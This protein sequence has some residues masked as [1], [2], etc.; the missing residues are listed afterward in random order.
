MINNLPSNVTPI[1]YNDLNVFS[2]VCKISDIVIFL[3]DYG[4]NIDY[5]YITLLF[6]KQLV[7]KENKLFEDLF[8]N[9]KNAYT[10]KSKED[11]LLKFKKMVNNRVAN[12]TDVAYFLIKDNTFDEI[13]K[14]YNAY[15]I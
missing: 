2:D 9:S 8:I 14:K 13:I 4:I 11:L 6:K 5:V 10:F 3:E 1:K 12:L 7:I 15:L